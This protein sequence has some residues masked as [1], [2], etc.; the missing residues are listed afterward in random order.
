MKKGNVTIVKERY[1]EIKEILSGDSN[2]S[3]F[4]EGLVE[5]ATRYISHVD[6]MSTEVKKLSEDDRLDTPSFY[7]NQHMGAM[8]SLTRDRRI[9]HDSLI[10]KLNAMNRYLFKT[11][12]DETPLG[13]IYTLP[14][15]TIKDRKAVGAWARHLV[16]AVGKKK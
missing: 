14:R 3:N 15:D 12:P 9:Y 6:H 1:N 16:S 8:E 11:F 13:G 7:C 5:C 4:L 2:A 10:S